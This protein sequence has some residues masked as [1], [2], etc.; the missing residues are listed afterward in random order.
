MVFEHARIVNKRYHRAP[1][2]FGELHAQ[3]EIV[4][5]YTATMRDEN[6]IIEID[7]LKTCFFTDVG[8][9]M[10]VNGVSFDRF[11]IVNTGFRLVIGSW[12]IMVMSLPRILYIS[13]VGIFAMS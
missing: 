3:A 4:S 1:R 6:N 11:P 13:T 2:R 9:V 12:K 10:S 8:T 5:E 7:G